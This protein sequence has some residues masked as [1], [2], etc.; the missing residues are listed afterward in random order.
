MAALIQPLVDTFNSVG[1]GASQ[2]VS[3]CLTVN[4]Y[5][6]GA[7]FSALKCLY[8]NTLSLVVT[9]IS[10]VQIILEDLVI[11]LG[12]LFDTASSILNYV[13]SILESI[14]EAGIS[15]AA[16]VHTAASSAVASTVHG[17]QGLYIAVLYCA[18]NLNFFFN[19][20][21]SSCLMLV[22]LVPRTLYIL[23]T[24]I[25]SLV[26]N[27]S[28]HSQYTANKVLDRIITAPAEL[29]LGILVGTCSIGLL[30]RLLVRTVADHHLTL[31]SVASSLLRLICTVY[32]LIIRSVA[33]GI[34]F[35]FTVVEV[36]VSNLR[37]PMISHAGDSDDEDEDR[38]NLVGEIEDSDDEDRAREAQKRKNYDLLIKRRSQQQERVC[39][40]GSVEDQLLREVERERE[41]K[42]CV[43]CVDKE[44]CIMILPCRHLCICEGCQA[45]L[46][47]HR[48]ICPICRKP[49]KQ[50]I[51]AYL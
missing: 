17:V 15:T 33:R 40:E 4:F 45:P 10:A 9:L 13:A 18:E 44:K 49:V 47:T 30:G 31:D 29:Y 28:T 2:L 16:S 34:G 7:I 51:K 22:N 39:S 19:L 35:I 5:L 25:L 6:G 48:N 42:L 21:G 46:R 3:S 41:D 20:L 11:F 43:I 23:S 37:L 26:V 50:L 12:E 38:E 36:T 1:S 8:L 32:V 24:S 14:W 27:F